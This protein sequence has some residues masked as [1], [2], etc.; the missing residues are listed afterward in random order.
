[1]SESKT[2]KPVIVNKGWGTEIIFANTKDYC[3][4]LLNFNKGSK[5]SMHFHILKDESW[6]IF[7]GKIKYTW[8]DPTNGK[9]EHQILSVGDVVRNKIGNPH[10]VE[11]LEETVI[12]EVSTQHL[13]EDS[14]R[15]F[16]GDSQK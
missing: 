15:I 9:Q 14:Y 3:G 12:F 11:A 5:C 6:Y 16:P 7:K 2:C 4:K 8:I 1:M 10:Q 13:D